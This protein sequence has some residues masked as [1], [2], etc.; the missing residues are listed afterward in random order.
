MVNH[1]TYLLFGQ[2]NMVGTA[3]NGVL[4]N[5]DGELLGPQSAKIWNH[6]KLT[7]PTIS[8]ITFNAPLETVVTFSA[9]HGLDMIVPRRVTLIIAGNG[10]TTAGVDLVNGTHVAIPVST[11]QVKLK[12]NVNTGSPHATL[13]TAAMEGPGVWEALDATIGSNNNQNPAPSAPGFYGVEMRLA[14][15]LSD[16]HPGETVH[17]H[18]FAI[19][20]STLAQSHDG[21]AWEADYMARQWGHQPSKEQLFR[22][23]FFGRWFA[24]LAPLLPDKMD[25]KGVFWIQGESD[26]ALPQRALAYEGLLKELMTQIEIV[27]V[28]E[29][30]LGTIGDYTSPLPWVIGRSGVWDTTVA[31]GSNNLVTV[32]DAQVQAALAWAAGYIFDLKGLPLLFDNLHLNDAGTDQAAQAAYDAFANQT[33]A[34]LAMLEATETAAAA[35]GTPAELLTALN[36]A[37][38]QFLA[39][40]AL[41]TYTVEGRTFQRADLGTMME[42]RAVLLA[43][44]AAGKAG[45]AVNYFR[46]GSA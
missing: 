12:G 27:L 22:L 38:H 3:G 26:A 4:S 42:Q 29:K 41:Q 30:L 10:G 44:Q 32:R 23:F 37:I 7:T 39:D 1:P 5:L 16:A 24:S 14:K 15:L 21:V 34:T 45:G 6:Q 28:V 35:T 20:G 9:A 18:K 31:G 25:I 33:R 19:P 2:S 11:T 40:G 36:L 46:R 13:G 43:E 8:A 17:L